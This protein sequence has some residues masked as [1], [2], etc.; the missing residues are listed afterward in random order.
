[1]RR[2]GDDLKLEQEHQA[3][4]TADD[5]EPA[6]ALSDTR[7]GAIPRLSNTSSGVQILASG[8]VSPG[9][10]NNSS[11]ED[12]LAALRIY[13]RA[14]FGKVRLA[15]G[16]FAQVLDDILAA[17]SSLRGRSRVGLFTRLCTLI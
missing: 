15:K 1:M 12:L 11:K 7:V 9:R 16:E 6:T 8:T 13:R 2:V 3:S 14:R 4:S 5:E 10:L 17:V